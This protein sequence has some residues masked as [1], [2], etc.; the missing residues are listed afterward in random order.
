M[1]KLTYSSPPSSTPSL[2]PTHKPTLRI[3]HWDLERE[4][5]I[6]L[7]DN[8]LIVVKYNFIN[9]SVEELKYIPFSHVTEAV[10]GDF[11]YTSTLIL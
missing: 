9:S 2:A 7:T 11:Q 8:S 10:Y 6:V 4:R 5:L 1:Y 3:D